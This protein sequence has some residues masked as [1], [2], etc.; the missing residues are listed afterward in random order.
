VGRI[1]I[2]YQDVATAAQQLQG[3][4]KNPTVDNVRSILGTGSK[5][6]IARHLKEWKSQQ[7]I[8]TASDGAIPAWIK[9]SLF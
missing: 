9:I 1:G 5:S 6:T 4:S 7:G 2:I 8:M 3:L